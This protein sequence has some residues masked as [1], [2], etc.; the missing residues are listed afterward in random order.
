[1]YVY[2][3]STYD[4]LRINYSTPKKINHST[5]QLMSIRLLIIFHTKM[6]MYWTSQLT[7][8]YYNYVSKNFH[9]KFSPSCVTWTL[10]LILTIFLFSMEEWHLF[11]VYQNITQKTCRNIIY[12]NLLDFE[13]DLCKKKKLLRIVSLLNFLITI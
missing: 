7:K 9:T 10:W 8:K 13:V 11:K 3:S 1:M 2:K 4:T 12:I 5:C 6:S